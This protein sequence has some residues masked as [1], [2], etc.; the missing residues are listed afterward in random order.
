VKYK[1]IKG[2]DEQLVV[3]GQRLV[4][5]VLSG[6]RLE[7]F[8][9][10]G[11]RFQQCSF[12]DVKF[13][14]A[15]WGAGRTQSEY[16]NCCF[17]GAT[18]RSVVPGNA[19]F[20][21]CSFRNVRIHELYGHDVELVD[22]VFSGCIDKGFLNGTRDPL[23]LRFGLFERLVGR[24]KNQISG[25]DFS[26]CELGDFSF[27]T[28]IDLEQQQLPTGPQYLHLPDVALAIRTGRGAIASWPI[29]E[30][31]RLASILLDIMA[32][33]LRAGQTQQFFRPATRGQFALP[34]ERLRRALA[35]AV[36][37]PFSE[38]RR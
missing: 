20:V 14:S 22:C 2:A 7:Y 19:R 13:G 12:R 35:D 25:N 17:D 11:S 10:I 9:A 5:G 36:P 6:R 16:T 29:D 26:Q 15:V 18:F 4:G 38:P 3:T 8:C 27:R 21:N 30:T 24:K 32:D 1:A 33:D 23:G 28:G 37:T 34:W 31:R